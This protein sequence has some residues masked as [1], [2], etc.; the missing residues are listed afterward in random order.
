M[1][2]LGGVFYQRG[3]YA[4]AMDWLEKALVIEG[5][6]AEIMEHLGDCHLALKDK[7]KARGAYTKALKNCTSERVRRRI[8]RKLEGLK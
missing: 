3:R 6:D 8:E 2:S 4:E 5:E 1:D 7:Q